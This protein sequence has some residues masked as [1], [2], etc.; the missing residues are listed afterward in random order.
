MKKEF[1]ILLFLCPLVFFFVFSHQ[2]KGTR[3]NKPYPVTMHASFEMLM[4]I[5]T[6]GWDNMQTKQDFEDFEYYKKIYNENYSFQFSFDSSLRIP[7]IVHFIWLGPRSFPQVSVENIR[8]WMKFH[9]DWTFKFWTDRKRLPPCEG[10]EVHYINDFEFKY[11]KDKFNLSQNWAAKADIFRYEILYQE[12]GIY[13][14]HDVVCLRSFHDLHSGY[15]FYAALEIPH[16]KIDGLAITPN[17]AVIGSKPGHPI[18]K[19]AMQDILERWDEVEEK[20]FSKDPATQAAKV[21]NLTL[22]ALT[23]SVKKNLGHPGNRDIIFPALYFYPKYGLPSFYAEHLYATT[24][25]HLEEKKGQKFLKNLFGIMQ[26]RDVKIL[27]VELITL[28]PLFGCFIL[29]FLMSRSLK[30][31]LRAVKK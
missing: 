6:E 10:M 14:D 17:V 26:E 7:K 11:L 24:W 20:F 13:I 25:N 15:D 22:I 30:I 27:K 5:D 16:E 28:L 19:G 12:G 2:L 1:I 9:P 8:T 18:M 3:P 21:V 23:H 29:Y 4:G 31:C